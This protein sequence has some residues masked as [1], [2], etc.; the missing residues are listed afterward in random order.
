MKILIAAYEVSALGPFAI[1]QDAA[2]QVEGFFRFGLLIAEIERAKTLKDVAAL[3]D[4]RIAGAV[5][6]WPNVLM[7]AELAIQELTGPPPKLP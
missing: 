3:I 4:L 5:L 7:A 2:D 6:G 1:N